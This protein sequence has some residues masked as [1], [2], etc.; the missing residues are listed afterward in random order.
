MASGDR[1]SLQA[2]VDRLARLIRADPNKARLDRLITR[3]LKRHLQRL[4]AQIDLTQI[5]SLVAPQL[6]SIG[7]LKDSQ[8]PQATGLSLAQ[9][10]ALR[11]QPPS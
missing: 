4:G 1:A 9:I 8:I 5:N 2:A 10:E 11:S 7:L 6:I 3:W